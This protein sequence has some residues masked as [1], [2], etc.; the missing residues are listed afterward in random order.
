MD[1]VS[2]HIENYLTKQI[3]EKKSF[4]WKGNSLQALKD[5]NFNENN[6]TSILFIDAALS[7]LYANLNI[8]NSYNEIDNKKIFVERE[9]ENGNFVYIIKSKL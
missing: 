9:F 6:N 2:K 5:F 8:E 1:K 4:F 7:D 3:N